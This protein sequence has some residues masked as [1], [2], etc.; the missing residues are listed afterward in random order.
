MN[1]IESH[2]T[3]VK[4]QTKSQIVPMTQ[5]TAQLTSM[6]SS[7]VADQ[8]I[9]L[10]VQVFR[11][12]EL[13]RDAW[14]ELQK[15]AYCLGFQQYN[16]LSAVWETVG[17]TR[18]LQLAI[19]L[20][21]D[22]SGRPM[23][24]VPLAERRRNGLRVLEFIDYEL[25]DYNA[26]LVR[27]EFIHHLGH[28]GFKQLWKK[29]LD[30]IGPVDA[31][32]LEK[33]PP[34][35]GEA[36][37]PFLQLSARQHTSTF[38]ASLAGGFDSFTKRRPTKFMR[39]LRRSGR[40]LEK[41]GKVE[42]TEASNPDEALAILDRML[43]L[44]SA[45]CRVTGADNIFDSDPGYAE[46][47]R[48]L[49]RRELGGLVS[50]GSLTA[51]GRFVAGNLGLVFGNR[52][53]GLIQASDYD[54]FGSHSPGGLLVLE[55]IRQFCERG[56]EILDFSLGSEAY[57]VDWTD[58]TTPL[59]RH[60]QGLTPLGKIVVAQQTGYAHLKGTIK[61]NPWLLASLKMAKAK[62]KSLKK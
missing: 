21:S 5:L 58:E 26:P 8:G 43:T 44:K 7:T 10:D 60:D 30:H 46:F 39:N 42:L 47:Y 16:W 14:I 48:V 19:V 17:H 41:L 4:T 35:I 62:L 13:V 51:D 37:N 34:L 18:S 28:S 57:K 31:I 56:F 23:M 55:V 50:I 22:N 29:I 9:D 32:H 53:C 20:V 38:Q 12:L 61:K 49:C 27:R 3:N 11:S 6:D 45:R 24:L 36:E 40:N 1:S 54:N 15:D 59:Y 52:F 2:A 33:M 25:C